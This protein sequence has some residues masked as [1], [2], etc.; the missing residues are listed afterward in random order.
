M[1]FL[2]YFYLVT[3][4][5]NSEM[6]ILFISISSIILYSIGEFVDD[7]NFVASDVDLSEEEFFEDDPNDEPE[8]EVAVAGPVGTVI[9]YQ[10]KK[11][12]PLI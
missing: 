9:L 7:V 11:L 12:Y 4:N 8:Y 10:I 5:H 3:V 2:K 6:K 1:I